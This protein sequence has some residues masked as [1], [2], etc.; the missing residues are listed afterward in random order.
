MPLAQV[1][2]HHLA[3]LLVRGLWGWLRR[4]G[5]LVMPVAAGVAVVAGA[6]LADASACGGA[7]GI[8]AALAVGAVL[9]ALG[10]PLGVFIVALIGRKPTLLVVAFLCVLQF[11]WTMHSERASLGLSGMLLS[12]LAVCGAGVSANCGRGCSTASADGQ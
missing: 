9:V 3:W 8:G 2:Y 4:A 7:S 12:T 11:F 5:P 1:C 6:A 10:A